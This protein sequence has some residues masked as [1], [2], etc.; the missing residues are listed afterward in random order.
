MGTNYYVR[1]NPCANCCRHDE[2][3]IGKQSAGWAFCFAP[4]KESFSEWKRV[5]EA[6]AEGIYDEYGRRTPLDDFLAGIEHTKGRLWEGSAP[7]EQ[8][9]Y[10]RTLLPQ[11]EYLD[12]DGYRFSKTEGFS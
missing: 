8:Y 9:P 10:R 2:V 11:Y 3:H 4:F 7:P 1:L 12:P 6:N 5:L